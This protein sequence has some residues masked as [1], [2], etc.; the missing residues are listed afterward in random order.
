MNEAEQKGSAEARAGILP[1]Q[2]LRDAVRDGW[3]ASDKYRVPDESFQP[4]SLD[5][6]L[7]DYAHRLQ[8]SFIPG[9]ASVEEKLSDYAMGDRIDLRDGAVLERARPYLIPLAEGLRLPPQIK[10]RTNPKSSTGRLDVFTRVITDRG[11][12]FDE[13]AAGYSGGLYLEVFSRS[14]TIHVRQGLALNQL[15]L[16]TTDVADMR[17]VELTALHASQPLIYDRGRPANTAGITTASGLLLSVDLGGAG[18]VAYRAKKNSKLLDLSL[19]GHYDVADFWEVERPAGEPRRLVLE[20]EEF[21]LLISRERVRVP[22][23]Y[24][25]EMVAYDPTSG[26]L[27]THY[28]GFFDPGFGHG[29]QGEEQGSRAVLEVRAHDVPFVLEDGQKVFKLAFQP[30]SERPE[31]LYGAQIGSHYQGQE[32][33][34]SKQFRAPAVQSSLFS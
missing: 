2:R 10:A 22:P 27:R 8:C 12:Y 31:V 23:D 5:L 7:G 21:Y 6:R 32:L 13:V 3:I 26:E 33:S 18:S 1:V 9:D 29:A 25:A 30:M 19:D 34:L 11:Y 20:P 15:R 4:A 28:A 24:A 14:F 17:D 16:M